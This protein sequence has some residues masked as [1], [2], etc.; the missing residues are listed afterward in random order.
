[1]SAPPVAPI[2]STSTPLQLRWNGDVLEQLWRVEAWTD[3]DGRPTQSF[4]WRPVP[5]ENDLPEESYEIPEVI[6]ASDWDIAQEK[7]EA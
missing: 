6:A 3:I 4:E 5:R 1:M 2:Y 7:R